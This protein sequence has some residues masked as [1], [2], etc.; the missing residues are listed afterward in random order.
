MKS[1]LRIS[2]RP[3]SRTPHDIF[4]TP[5]PLSRIPILTFMIKY[6]DSRRLQRIR[7]RQVRR[8]QAEAQRTLE[9]ER[10]ARTYTRGDARKNVRLML[11]ALGLPVRR[12][13]VARLATGGTMSLSKLV[14]PFNLF[15]PSALKQLRILERAGLVET[16]KQGRVRLCFLR[17]DA[18]PE[19][20]RLLSSADVLK[21]LD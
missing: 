21:R 17:P 5:A 20:T 19:L 11:D 1:A 8:G 18:F 16:R 9:K 12:K 13:M 3:R 2:N 10:L 14:E 7:S 15:L 4:P 6:W